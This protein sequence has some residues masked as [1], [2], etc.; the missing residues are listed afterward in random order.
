MGR[1]LRRHR[2]PGSHPSGLTSR[3][4]LRRRFP[5]TISGNY[6]AGLTCPPRL[7]PRRPPL[8][9]AP[10]RELHHLPRGPRRAGRLV[11]HVH[12]T[13]TLTTTPER[14]FLVDYQTANLT[15]SGPTS[16]L[17]RSVA[18]ARATTTPVRG[19]HTGTTVPVR[20][21]RTR[22]R[23]LQ[24]EP[25][26]HVYGHPVDD[27]DA[28]MA[29][30]LLRGGLAHGRDGNSRLEREPCSDLRVL[31]HATERDQGRNDDRT[32][33]CELRLHPAHTSASSA[34]TATPAC[35]RSTTAP[36][37]RHHLDGTDV[38]TDQRRHRQQRARV[39]HLPRRRRCR[40]RAQLERQGRLAWTRTGSRSTTAAHG[41][42]H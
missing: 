17:N 30:S 19:C 38:A 35:R 22:T 5:V 9:G 39:R 10:G 41:H 26:R 25:R 20:P 8:G 42:G 32:R 13:L 1:G 23:D 40:R 14:V 33:R 34:T 7:G 15:D 27:M 18:T 36:P 11:R 16:G 31:P 29:G 4:Q 2:Q 24:P 28:T 21:T 37:R 12:G 3:R 6:A